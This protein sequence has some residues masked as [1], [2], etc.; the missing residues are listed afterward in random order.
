M[1][2]LKERHVALGVLPETIPDL[3]LEYINEVNSRVAGDKRDDTEVQNIAKAICW[4]CLRVSYRPAPARLAGV[5][6]ALGN[7][8]EALEQVQY[9]ESRLHLV[10]VIGASHDSLKFTLDPVAEYSQPCI[11]LTGTA[12][13]SKLGRTFL[14]RWTIFLVH[15]KPSVDFFGQSKTPGAQ[16]MRRN[17]F[18]VSSRRSWPEERSSST[19][20]RPTEARQSISL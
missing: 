5:K 20:P 13:T 14:K 3:M 2:S 1:I 9:F 15:P 19:R 10:E 7:G 11:S 17:P 6:S 12:M 8:E 4:E 18:R 16:S